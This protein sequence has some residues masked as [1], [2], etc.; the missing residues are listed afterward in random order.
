MK[1]NSSNSSCVVAAYRECN[2]ATT[3][4]KTGYS[5]TAAATH[6]ATVTL[7]EL[8]ARVLA[9]SQSNLSYNSL[10]TS[11]LQINATQQQLQL[12]NELKKLVKQIGFN[13]QFTSAEIDELL[14]DMLD[15]SSLEDA[16]ECCRDLAK[17]H[18]YKI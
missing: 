2:S 5:A 1:T 6:S 10:A 12:Q 4:K 16:V 18:P 3:P 11:Q 8:S 9:R 7:T 14:I 17:Y 13:N 15:Y